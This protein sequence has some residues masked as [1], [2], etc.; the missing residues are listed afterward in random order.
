MGL[1]T[2]GSWGLVHQWSSREMLEGYFGLGL[3]GMSRVG[4]EA[5]LSSRKTAYP[6]TGPVPCQPEDE[7][8]PVVVGLE[9]IASAP[10]YSWP[11]LL[12][13]ET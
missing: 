13:K 5:V 8:S 10:D 6:P 4:V 7:R 1:V 11:S 9:T 12:C 2:R 3:M